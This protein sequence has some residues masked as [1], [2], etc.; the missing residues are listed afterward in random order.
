MDNGKGWKAVRR[1]EAQI[2][3]TPTGRALPACSKHMVSGKSRRP[4]FTVTA[5]FPPYSPV[6]LWSA[7]CR[8]CRILVVVDGGAGEEGGDVLLVPFFLPSSGVLGDPRVA[9]PEFPIRFGIQ[10]YDFDGAYAILRYPTLVSLKT[11]LPVQAVCAQ[12]PISHRVNVP[13]YA[14]DIHEDDI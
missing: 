8:P 13:D 12:R 3:I 9:V 11:V 2:A 1:Q 10:S 6:S 7:Q 5:A 14:E 4:I